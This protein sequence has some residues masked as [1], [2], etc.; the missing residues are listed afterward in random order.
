MAGM[1]WRWAVLVGAAAAWGAAAAGWTPRGPLTPGQALW[2]VLISAALGG[3]AG[4]VTRSRWAALVAPAAFVTALEAARW[5]VPGPS[6]DGPHLSTFGI[7]AL[8]TG[9][10]LHGLLSVLPM[11]VGAAYGAARRD[12]RTGAWR[13][14]RRVGAGLAAALVV[15]VTVA[16]AVPART[17]AV[18]P[19]GVAEFAAVTVGDHRLGMLIRGADVTRPVLLYVPGGPGESEFGSFRR[20]LGALEQHFVVAVLDR[21]GAG[22]SYAGLD[23]VRSYTLDSAVQ[24]VVAVTDHLR[25][26]FGQDRIL[27]LAHSGGSLLG[28][29]AAHRHPEKYRAYV[30]TGQAV[31]LPGTDRMFYDDVLAWARRTGDDALAAGLVAQGPPPYAGFW[32]YEP[33]L[34]NLNRVYPYD[35][36]RNA[37][38][39]GGSTEN[40]GVAEYTVL[41]QLH[42][43][44]T[45]M[46]T[47][48]V[49]YPQMQ[50]IDLRTDVPRLAV[51]AYFVQG[52]HEMRGLAVP[53]AEW[54][55]ALDAPAKHLIVLGT[56]GHRPPFE[57]PAD[58]VAA[59][60][61]VLA[62]TR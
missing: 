62:E 24:D 7:I 53:F 36:S 30:G 42:A 3:L 59:M 13:I 4:R 8:V 58:F 12:R 44:V 40:L 9:R 48:T 2:S 28:A 26:R 22:R 54:Y 51:P 17:A 56:S 57:Q 45:V 15:A 23:P 50:G 39:D 25:G 18:G 43:G 46:D 55:A 49:L 34:T 33:I 32:P 60:T 14:V 1:W 6:V 61:R 27:L 29:L 47:W 5:T 31:H 10:G 11:I 38:G 16:V 41:E 52:A 21:R 35:R 19:G 37:E 20:H